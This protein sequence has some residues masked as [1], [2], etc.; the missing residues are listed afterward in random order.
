ME[1]FAAGYEEL[2]QDYQVNAVYPS[3][4]KRAMGLLMLHVGI[5]VEQVSRVVGKSERSLQRWVA[6][7][8]DERMAS[9]YRRRVD[10]QNP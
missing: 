3:M 7:W 2:L 8:R 5:P 9:L 4:R 1:G 6:E 10:Q